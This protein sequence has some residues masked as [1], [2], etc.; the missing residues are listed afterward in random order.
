MLISFELFMCAEP[1]SKH[2]LIQKR[3]EIKKKKQVTLT[4]SKERLKNL[5]QTEITPYMKGVV[6]P[7][8][9]ALHAK[10]FFYCFKK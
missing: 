2:V 9:L 6:P 10:V 8:R 4:A 5:K 3:S 7:Q 1:K